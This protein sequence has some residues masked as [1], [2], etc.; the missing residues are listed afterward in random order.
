MDIALVVLL[1]VVGVGLLLAEMFLL[2]GFG[3]A[4][5]SGFACLAGSVACAYCYISPMAG[6]LTLAVAV[7]LF[8]T[9]VYAFLK[10]KTLDKMALKTDIDAKVDLIKGTNVQVGDKGICVSRLAPMGKVRVNETEFE[11]KSRDEFLDP[12]TKIEVLAIEGNVLIVRSI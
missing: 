4:G 7:I 1:L 10:S 11:A 6:H 12:N 3:I 9:S 8:A 5:I 2:P